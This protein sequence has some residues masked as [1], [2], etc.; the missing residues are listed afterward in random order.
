MT[1]KNESITLSLSPEHKSALEKQA[2]AAGCTWGGVPNI[3]EY[4][5]RIAE[6]TIVPTLPAEPLPSDAVKKL[7]RMVDKM[8]RTISELE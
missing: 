4:M 6:G 8:S 3:S 5:R 1:R 7:R 2:A